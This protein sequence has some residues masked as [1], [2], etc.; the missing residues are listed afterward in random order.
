TTEPEVADAAHPCPLPPGGGEVRFRGVR[1]SYGRPDPVLDGF[2]LTIA[3]GESVALVGQTGA[4]K[5]TV[6]RL[7][8]RFYDV[9]DGTITIDGADIR[10]LRLRDL[11]RSVGIVF[12]DT[13]LFSDSIAANIA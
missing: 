5:T 1:F 12:E 8:P 7:I 3:A 4:G 6:A 2:D 11:R 10:E 9:E 13:F